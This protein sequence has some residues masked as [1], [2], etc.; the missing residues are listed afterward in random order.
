MSAMA[1]VALLWRGATGERPES[2]RNFARLA[3][4]AEALSA[5]GVMVEPMLFTDEDADFVFDRLV[6]LDG[7]LVWVDP[8]DGTDTRL[9]LDTMLRRLSAAGVWVSAHPNTIDKIGTK[10]VLYRSKTLSWGMDTHLYTSAAA[11][12]S[13]LP[14]RLAGGAPRVLKR[15]HGNGGV[16][17]WKV[18]ARERVAGRPMVRV[19]H[20]A[21]RDFVTEDLP[22]DMFVDRCQEYFVAGGTVIDQPFAPRLAEG[23]IRA[24]LTGAEV[25]GFAR[26]H[27]PAAPPDAPGGAAAAIF[28]MPSAKTMFDA[29]ERSLA[30][31]RAQLEQEWIPGLCELV[32]L[33]AG[34]LPVLWDADFLYG[35]PDP[36]GTD[37]YVLCEINA[38]SVLPFPAGAPTAV[39][40]AVADRLGTTTERQTQQRL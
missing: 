39:A 28:G 11:L 24:Y 35:P 3:P 4:M 27:P 12:H 36:N 9:V 37:T 21:P 13:E 29:T 16:G 18:T 38:R 26:Q 30:R 17:V 6:R 2:T 7:V 25:V 32:R 31:L 33:A 23:M 14:G 22:L 34:D 10:E 19:Q 8:L 15:C 5:A 20:A 40:R 1:A